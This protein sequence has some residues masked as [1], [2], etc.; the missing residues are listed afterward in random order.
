MDRH[1]PFAEVLGA[2]SSRR[3]LLCGGLGAAALAIVGCAAADRKGQRNPPFTFTGVPTSTGDA[4]IVPPGYTAEVLFAWGDPVSAGPVFRADASATSTEQA[5]QAGMHHDG[6]HFFPLPAGSRS[7]SRG[8]LAINHEY[9]DEALLHAGGMRPWTAEKVAKS[10]AAHGVSVI[11]VRFVGGRWTVVRP[12]PYA[13]RVTARTRVD[14]DGPAAGHPLLRTTADPAGRTVL[15]TLN[16]CAHGMTPWGTYLTCEENFHYYFAAQARRLTAAARRYGIGRAGRA[17]RW[18][19]H[20]GRFNASAHP[21][22]PH[23]FGWVVEIDPYD[24]G[25]APVKHTA[26]GRFKH[27]GAAVTLAADGRVVVF[28]GDDESFEYIYKFVSRDAYVPG[29]REASMR[30]LEAGALYAARFDADGSGEWLALAHGRHGLD[31]AGGFS[32]EAAGL[33]HARLAADRVGATAMDR[34]EWIAIHPVTGEVYCALTHNSAR[35]AAGRPGTDAA[36]PRANNVLG[37]IVRWRPRGG[38]PAGTRFDWDVFL[39]AGDPTHANP[40]RR[41]TMKGD[42][43]GSPDGLT[44]D[45]HGVLW[46]QTDVSAAALLRGDHAA[47]GNN[48]VLAADPATGEVR[49]FLTGPPGCELTGLVFAPDSRTMFVNVQHPGESAA[50]TDPARPTAVSSWPDGATGG[51]PRSATIAVRRHDGGRIGT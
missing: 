30:L 39:L 11:E 9:T 12:S 5:Q 16:N 3:R 10:Q 48:Q 40:S 2:R 19:E 35:G 45:A 34:P 23:R 21:N 22:E 13:R 6:M 49:R 33:V 32:D 17:F 47:L 18:H 25:R 41:G 20:D 7:A 44:F 28:M 51:R 1:P 26:L 29:R 27:E 43:F 38:D 37:H 46:I 8:L 14:V 24:P 15:G 4:V 36:N 50:G 42:A 31:D